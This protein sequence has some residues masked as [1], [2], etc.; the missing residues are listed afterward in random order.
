MATG[1]VQRWKGKISAASIWYGGVNTT[2]ADNITSTVISA[3]IAGNGVSQIFSTSS[4]TV[5]TLGQPQ[6]GLDRNLVIVQCSSGVLF[7]AAPGSYFAFGPGSSFTVMKSTAPQASIC[8]TGL[9]TAA[10]GILGAWST[11]T[12]AIFSPTFSTT[13]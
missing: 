9:S 11:S 8:L 7:K 3:T 5:L 2:G 12:A 4:A 1:F 6:P 10:W 13:T